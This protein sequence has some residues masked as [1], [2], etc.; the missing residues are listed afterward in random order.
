MGDARRIKG[1][2]AIRNALQK[3]TALAP[4]QFKN[5]QGDADFESSFVSQD[6]AKVF[7]EFV[8]R[9]K[10]DDGTGALPQQNGIPEGWELRGL[11]CLVPW[12]V[13]ALQEIADDL[14]QLKKRTNR[15]AAEVDA[16]I[17][18]L[19]TRLAALETVVPTSQQRI[20]TAE[21]R[22]TALE[23]INASKP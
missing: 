15:K 2:K 9:R 17:V 10:N 8:K 19:E 5:L 6:L 13:S 22:I 3:I 16:K 12:I 14:D 20:V 1:L 18:T 11:E 4:V 21:D 7:P 23:K